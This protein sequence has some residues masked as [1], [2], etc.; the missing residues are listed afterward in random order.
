MKKI[1]C[2]IIVLS[3]LILSSCTQIPKAT[4]FDSKSIENGYNNYIAGGRMAYLN[5]NL[6]VTYI[7]NDYNTLGTYKFN[8][9]GV[10]HILKD[11]NKMGDYAFEAPKF[12]QLDDK[13]YVLDDG[14]FLYEDVTDSLT[15]CDNNEDITSYISDDLKVVW[16]G[17]LNI[18]YKDNPEFIIEGTSD[19]YV[20]DD[21][22]YYTNT[23]EWLYCID[24]AKSQEREFLSYLFES[25]INLLH[26]CGDKVYFDHD[27]FYDDRYKTGL[28]CY[29]MKDD[30]IEL[31]LEGEI[32][33]LNSYE[34]MLY[35]ATDKGI[36]TLEGK[37]TDRSAKSIYL[38]DEDWIYAVQNDAGNVYRVSLDGEIV[39]QINFLDW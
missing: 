20:E 26:V 28:Y 7:S 32:N 18:V 16:D 23:D 21:K 39:E 1:L 25:P 8:N 11:N 6:Y 13:L 36:F 27:S 37:I 15:V 34:D 2:I 17:K 19:Y 24:I 10:S 38:L 4:T 31:V 12:Y 14:T 30:E 22:I 29:S 3:T 5:N 9:D 33:C 35:I